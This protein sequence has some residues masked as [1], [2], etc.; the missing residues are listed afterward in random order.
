[1]SKENDEPRQLIEKGFA[2]VAAEFKT[3][4]E[5]FKSQG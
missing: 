2:M 1:M 3:V 4:H 5:E